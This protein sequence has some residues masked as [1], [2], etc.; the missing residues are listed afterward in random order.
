MKKKMLRR[1][2]ATVLSAAIVT[3]ALPVN[4]SVP[5]KNAGVITA[6]AA[7]QINEGKVYL[8][9]D[10]I[11]SGEKCIRT[12]FKKES[13]SPNKIEKIKL[14]S[15]NYDSRN[16]QW[17]FRFDG[18]NL[19]IESYD[20]TPI[21]GI[22]CTGGSG[23]YADPYCFEEYR[24]PAMTFDANGGSGEMDKVYFEEE[25]WFEFP[26]CGFTAPEGYKFN[27]WRYDGE[28][29]TP[30]DG[31]I[32]Y[33]DSPTT[34]TADWL[35][36]PVVSFDAN[37]GTGSMD[38]FTADDVDYEYTLP[39][40]TFTAPEGQTFNYWEVYSDRYGYMGWNNAGD[41]I[42]LD[43]GEYSLVAY[44]QD[45]P[46][47]TFDANGGTGSMDGFTAEEMNVEYVLPECG[48]T[49]PEGQT[50][51]YWEVSNS[52]Y[53]YTDYC[54]AGETITL[55]GG[56]TTIKPVWQDLPYV[57]FDANGG[58][59]TMDSF[60]ADDVNYEYTLPKCSFTAPEGM[61]FDYW[62]IYHNGEWWSSYDAGDKI[63]LYGGATTIQAVWK[64]LPKISFDANG[65]T[66]SMESIILD[67]E[68]AEY[69]LPECGFTA[70][71]GMQFSCWS[72]IENGNGWDVGN[73]LP[74]ESIELSSGS[75]T[76]RPVWQ[77][78]PY[79][80]F[81]A[82]GGEGT[83]E[84]IIVPAGNDTYPLPECTFTPPSG[85]A[86]SH[87]STVSDG[88]WYGTNYDA[89]ED[90][91]VHVG[92]N[93]IY[94]IWKEVAPTFTTNSMI[95]E[96]S[97]IL[98]FAV[99]MGSME[100]DYYDLAYVE[101]NVNG[102]TQKAYWKDSIKKSDNVYK[103]KCRLNSISMADN[104]EAV[105]HYYDANGEE[106]TVYTN[107][108][109]EEYL[110]K[111]NTGNSSTKTLNLIKAI[112]D[113]GYYMQLF[114]SKQAAMPW[115]LG[116]DHAAMA[117]ANKKHPTY[118]SSKDT[119]IKELKEKNIPKV[120]S[121]TKDIAKVNYSLVLESDTSI[122]FKIKKADG[123]NGKITVKV[124]GKIIKNPTTLSDG[125]LQV[126][127]SG[128]PAHKLA[129]A[130]TVEIITASGTSTFKASA[131]SYAY[132]VMSLY[133]QNTTAMTKESFD[134]MCALYEYYK[135]T[136]AYKE[137]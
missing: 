87:W 44:W 93:I 106:Q 116:V 127:V 75:Y 15:P 30:G 99:D 85:L 135:A 107:R 8:I 56:A 124:D 91:S 25:D 40:C 53:G 111:F 18:F 84:E 126:T 61:T 123:Y 103:F 46:Y 77:E 55:Y 28:L 35:K 130:H 50:F 98:T 131:L 41:K 52:Y 80:I 4:Y 105:L 59:G 37:G 102:T 134:G 133:A 14:P 94:P 48:F 125:R 16:H 97:I 63:T 22:I 13:G 72:I 60:T 118:L 2:A 136:V 137:G 31:M 6:E 7:D 57:T 104:I 17:V 73:R 1:A 109:C 10:T 115:T 27:G 9:G 38:G 39:E 67:T 5:G 81:D 96:G 89:G 120:T 76:I 86:F 74:N 58:T 12:D 101:F 42:T 122:N 95:L 20:N 54:N 119:Y 3:G 11:D 92:E 132:D 36:L 45:L 110:N 82:N 65:G 70:P 88:S 117:K 66:G 21:D 33:A 32:L 49:A 64:E 121:Y 19:Y 29:F 78:L 71:E 47:V 100:K 24:R 43:S 68:P 90:M 23:D 83:M 79:I 113:Y 114:L 51:N 26:E 108:T 128:I 129:E 34:I 69:V 112:N 62:G